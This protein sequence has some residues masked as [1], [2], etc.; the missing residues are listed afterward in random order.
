LGV[1]GDRAQALLKMKLNLLELQGRA[2]LQLQQD[3][4]GEVFK[5][6]EECL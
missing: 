5:K 3:R 1:I 2:H 4:S 6:Y